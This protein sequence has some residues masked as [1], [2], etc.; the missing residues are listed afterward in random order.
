[1][2]GNFFQLIK[3]LHKHIFHPSKHFRVQFLFVFLRFC[4][5]VFLLT[6]NMWK[7]KPDLNW[8]RCICGINPV[9]EE[10][11]TKQAGRRHSFSMITLPEISPHPC[12][13][14]AVYCFNI[15]RSRHQLH[16]INSPRVLSNFIQPNSYSKE[17]SSQRRNAWK[18]ILLYV[19]DM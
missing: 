15:N 16:G 9:K 12:K 11:K 18:R 19:N 2:F 7:E 10:E 5:S 4:L 14:S 17:S 8:R 3:L 6:E 13:Q 1:M